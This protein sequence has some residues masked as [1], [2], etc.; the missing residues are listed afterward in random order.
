MMDAPDA[1]RPRGMTPNRNRFRASRDAHGRNLGFCGAFASATGREIP[2]DPGSY[3]P[4]G[5]SP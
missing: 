4:C 1:G 5:E 3:A 2:F